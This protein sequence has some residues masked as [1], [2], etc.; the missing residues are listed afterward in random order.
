M[1]PK[2]DKQRLPE[3]VKVRKMALEELHSSSVA[4]GQGIL[5]PWG[6]L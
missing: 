1:K 2:R 5:V 3:D 4:T 6:R